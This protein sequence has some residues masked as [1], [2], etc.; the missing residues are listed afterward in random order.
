[1]EKFGFTRLF[2]EKI[3][4]LHKLYYKAAGVSPD[5]KLRFKY[6]EKILLHQI[7]KMEINNILDAGCG[8]GDYSFY[9]SKFFPDSQISAIDINQSSIKKNM[10]LQKKIGAKNIKFTVQDL[11]N[12]EKIKKFDIILCI[13]VL[14]HITEQKKVLNSFYN[15]LKPGGYLFVHIPIEK[16]KPVVLHKYLSNF[17]QWEKEEHIAL[18]LLADNFLR[19]LMDCGFNIE[20]KQ[21]SFNHYLGEFAVSLILLFHT[22]NF[23]NKLIKAM[24][25]PLL[26]ILIGL[27]I[28]ISNKS[29]NAIAILSR[30]RNTDN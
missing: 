11:N 10:I 3:S 14:E 24:L 19:M 15:A 13:D 8:G 21:N 9:F 17:H 16:K 6:C 2:R 1:M 4:P 22:Q 25:S 23:V 27:D 7:K 26:N 29:G 28:S 30:K 18:P 12:I 20:I 5:H